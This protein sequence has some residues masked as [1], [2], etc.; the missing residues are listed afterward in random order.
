[1]HKVKGARR[2]LLVARRRR[3]SVGRL[4]RHWVRRIANVEP[5]LA[6]RGDR[7]IVRPS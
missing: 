5:V 3:V 1:M 4:K 6:W 7:P 2:M